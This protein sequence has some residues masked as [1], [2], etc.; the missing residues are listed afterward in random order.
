L[1]PL[2]DQDKVEDGKPD[3]EKRHAYNQYITHPAERHGFPGA[4]LAYD[5][6]IIERGR[7][8]ALWIND[9]R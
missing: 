5:S 6:S 7:R 4:V 1:S 3:D 2:F 8:M 9:A